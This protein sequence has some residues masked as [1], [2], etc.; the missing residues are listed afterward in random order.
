ME[1][2]TRVKLHIPRQNLTTAPLFQPNTEA[3]RNWV[4]S[5]PVTNAI[6]VV[7]LLVHALSDLNRIKISPETRYDI[8]EILCPNVEVALTNLSRRY[9]HQALILPEAPRKMAELSYN[10]CTLTSTAYTIVA[11]EAI[12]QRDAL[13]AMNPARL[14]CEAIQRALLYAGRKVLLTFQLHRPMEI[15]GWQTL[16]QL[17]ALGE[18]Q[19]LTNLPVSEPLAGGSTITSTY[20]RAIILGCCKSNQLRQS[21]LTAIYRELQQW[22]EL[23]LLDTEDSE[24]ALFLV[25][26][27]SDQPPMYSSV[28][29]VAPKHPCRYLDA[30]ALVTHLKA[31]KETTINADTHFDQ[32]TRFPGAMF[33]HLIAALGSV[34][35]RNFKRSP[36]DSTLRICVGLSSTHFHVA[37]QQSFEQ[38][39]YGEDNLP[40]EDKVVSGNLL[41]RTNIKADTWQKT[42][43]GQDYTSFNEVDLSPEIDVDSTGMVKLMDEEEGALSPSERYPVFKVQLADFS[44]GGYCLEW[45]DEL[46]GNIKAGD[47]VCLKEEG[48]KDW[49]IAVIRWLSGLKNAKTLVGLELLSPRAIAY[50]ACIDI[51]PGEKSPP[52]RVLMLAEIALIGQPNTLVTPR[53]GFKEQ[54]QLSLGNSKEVHSVELLRHIASTGSFSQFEFRYIEELEGV[55]AKNQ[56]GQA[57]KD[58]DSVWSSI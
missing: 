33:D 27:N 57:T 7:E 43:P 23:V 49:V 58:F 25:A 31:L 14:T 10:L 40:C 44:S 42:N 45:N 4:E 1:D 19:R 9:L 13:R 12:Q 29:D 5:F 21:D 16:H 39:L 37:S 26:L 17:Y 34:S 30:T 54:Q 51:K 22:S 47:V 18:N 36:A 38:L 28:Y 24:Q 52:V 46:P 11:I 55:L 32:N 41:L 3:A 6:S 20:L 53:A 50:G 56:D 35:L 2:K 8:M 48:N 15:R